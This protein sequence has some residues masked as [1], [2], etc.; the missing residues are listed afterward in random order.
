[1]S[2]VST[3]RWRHIHVPATVEPNGG[4]VHLCSPNRK[5]FSNHCCCCIYRSNA[6][7]FSPASFVSEILSHS[8][9]WTER[10][11][12]ICVN[13]ILERCCFCWR[14]PAYLSFLGFSCRT[15]TCRKSDIPKTSLHS[16]ELGKIMSVF[17]KQVS[18]SA[19]VTV[20]LK[21][22]PLLK[23]YNSR[24]MA[25]GRWAIEHRAQLWTLIVSKRFFPCS[26]LAQ[27]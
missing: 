27:Q 24:Q 8:S 2:S 26:C 9:V 7:V 12:F 18:T 10:V 6:F 1:M 13:V 14:L 15:T 20:P 21:Q 23:P 4:H 17:I 3:K 19:E 16:N 25:M 5:L 11:I 22:G